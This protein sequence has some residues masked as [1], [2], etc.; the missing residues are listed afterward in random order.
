MARDVADDGAN[1]AVG[2]GDEVDEVA[3]EAHATLARG[4][5]HGYPQVAGTGAE[6]RDQA[7]L[8]PPVEARGVAFGLH[9]PRPLEGDG[10]VVGEALHRRQPC[11]LRLRRAGR[12]A[13]REDRDRSLVEHDRHAQRRGEVG[14][15]G[16]VDEKRRP[17]V[18][19]QIGDEGGLELRDELLLEIR[20]RI[21]GQ[22][23]LV[24]SSPARC[25]RDQAKGVALDRDQCG[26]GASRRLDGSLADSLGDAREAAAAM[27]RRGHVEHA[28]DRLTRRRRL[29]E[30]AQDLPSVT[31]AEH[32]RCDAGDQPHEDH[33]RARDPRDEPAV[34]DDQSVEGDARRQRETCSDDGAADESATDHDQ[35]GDGGRHADVRLAP[36]GE[37]CG[38]EQREVDHQRADEHAPRPGPQPSHRAHHARTERQRGSGMPVSDHGGL[39]PWRRLSPVGSARW[40]RLYLPRPAPVSLRLTEAGREPGH[41][42][43]PVP[44]SRREPEDAL[45]SRR[46]ALAA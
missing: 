32:A 30:R 35:R 10:C 33:D 15:P 42:R 11:R 5:A 8:E 2:K 24:A 45:A 36:V 20:E 38:D 29:I 34:G 37:V 39:L 18:A 7:G 1:P 40:R 28:L 4:V 6:L 12:P 27:E 22:G 25:P 9:A 16:E 13:K 23:Y 26:G 44:A 14:E 3:T 17:A 41:R 46:G 43:A 19:R 31:I 21:Q